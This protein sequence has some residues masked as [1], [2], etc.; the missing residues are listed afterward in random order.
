MPVYSYRC[1]QCA[2]VTDAF[3][4]VDDR[5]DC[6]RCSL[7]YAPT[8]KKI[9]PTMVSVFNPYKTAALD[10]ETGKP[11]VIRNRDEH[12]AFLARNGYEEVGNDARMAPLPDEEVS[13]RRNQ[14][15]KEQEATAFEFSEET[16]EAQI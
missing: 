8:V 12:R 4:K 5:E 7:C 3:R 1:T 9:V 16:H 10:K 14:M 11:M 2:K 15:L 6:P 13:Y